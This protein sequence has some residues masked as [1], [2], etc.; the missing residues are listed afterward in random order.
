MHMRSS[1]GILCHF[2]FA[3]LPSEAHRIKM[4]NLF[5]KYKGSYPPCS[6][7]VDPLSTNLLRL[8]KKPSLCGWSESFDSP[9]WGELWVFK[10]RDLKSLDMLCNN[11]H[12]KA[13][14]SLVRTHCH[15]VSC[16][17]ELLRKVRAPYEDKGAQF[18]LSWAWGSKKSFSWTH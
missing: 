15:V 10:F 1:Y 2:I 17:G 8:K 4:I 11:D 13:L 12:G 14:G 7:L 6:S 9:F 18:W 16:D 3:F 5:L